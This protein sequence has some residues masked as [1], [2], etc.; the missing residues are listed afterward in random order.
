[1]VDVFTSW[2]VVQKKVVYA[3]VRYKE[4]GKQMVT[5]P[6]GDGMLIPGRRVMVRNAN[7]FEKKVGRL[8]TTQSM[9]Q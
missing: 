2:S 6:D 7:S 3:F 9:F 5:I 8:V 1:M 4:E